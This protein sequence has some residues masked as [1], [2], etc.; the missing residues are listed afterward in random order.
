MST[1]ILDKN[2]ITSASL[3]RKTEGS[4]M[5]VSDAPENTRTSAQ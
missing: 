3:F 2:Y 5:V 4:N 1:I